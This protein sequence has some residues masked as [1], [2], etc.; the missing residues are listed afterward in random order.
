MQF[1][2]IWSVSWNIGVKPNLFILVF[3]KPK[4][5]NKSLNLTWEKIILV[6]WLFYFSIYLSIFLTL[7]E[8][9]IEASRNKETEK[10]VFH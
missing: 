5:S 1:D 8:K 10:G 2:S 9:I 6:F 7:L 4:K 3:S